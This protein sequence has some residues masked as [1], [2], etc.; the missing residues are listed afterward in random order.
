MALVKLSHNVISLIRW[1]KSL[2]INGGVWVE[3][4]TIILCHVYCM[5]DTGTSGLEIST[6]ES[7]D[8]YIKYNIVIITRQPC[9]KYNTIMFTFDQY[10]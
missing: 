2:E 8:Q 5:S 4:D 9:T 1:T 7:A 3:G 6:P 10:C